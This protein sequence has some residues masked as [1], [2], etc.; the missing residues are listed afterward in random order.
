MT[1]SLET[2]LIGSAAVYA[3]AVLLLYGLVIANS[4]LPSVF[5]VTAVASL[6][7]L[8]GLCYAFYRTA[9]HQRLM[10]YL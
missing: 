8:M 6:A 9:K 5:V 7:V 10:F 1:L 2:K 4:I 3:V